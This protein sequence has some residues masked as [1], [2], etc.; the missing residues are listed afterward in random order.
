MSMLVLIKGAGDLASGIACRLIRSGFQVIMTDLPR[1]TAVRCTVAFSSAVYQKEVCIE[2]ISG[3]LASDAEEARTIAA[4]GKVAVLTDPKCQCRTVLQPDVLVDA[5]IAKRNTGIGKTDAPIVIGVGPG[6]TA[7]E[8]CH[9]VVETKRGHDLGRVYYEGSAIPNTGVPG[10]IGGYSTERLVRSSGDGMFEPIASIG[11]IVQKGQ[12]VARVE[13]KPVC[14]Q[15]DGVLRGLLPA[16]TPVT[17]G[18]KAGDVD[19]RCEVRHCYS[20]SDKARAIGGGVLEGIL[21][22]MAIRRKEG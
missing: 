4:S 21:H 9:C 22:E 5:I 16:G 6:F 3:V 12:V 10:E 15:I 18:M 7:P 8:D 14:A 17:D 11:D 19:P 2:G 13:G 1:P 20:V